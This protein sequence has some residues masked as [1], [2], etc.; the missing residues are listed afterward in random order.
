LKLYIFYVILDKLKEDILERI[1]MINTMTSDQEL[2]VLEQEVRKRKRIMEL[3]NELTQMNH[4][5]QQ[6]KTH[7]NKL[8]FSQ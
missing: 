6:G 8:S 5:Q 4:F 3:R 7:T 1:R 2:E